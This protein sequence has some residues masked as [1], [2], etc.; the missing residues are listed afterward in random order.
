[1]KRLRA[2]VIL[3]AV[4]NPFD[5]HAGTMLRMLGAGSGLSSGGGGGGSCS[6]ATL[7]LN[8]CLSTGSI[9]AG[10]L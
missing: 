1:M 8:L 5:V 7:S 6:S 2:I 10:V 4:L 9:A 3:L